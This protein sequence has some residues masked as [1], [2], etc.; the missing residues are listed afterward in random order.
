MADGNFMQVRD[1]IWERATHL[2]WLNYS[3]PRILGRVLIRTLARI[4]RRERL[5][6][7]NRETLFKAFC[8]S[9]SII[10]WAV[11][12]FRPY[13]RR[14]R[15]FCDGAELPRLSRVELHNPRQEGQLLNALAVETAS[16][17]TPREV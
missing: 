8:T 7:D 5:Y 17:L 16:P 15:E 2:V 6:N 1:L 10:W 13:R 14:Y 3:F 9:D 4:I 11:K 12:T